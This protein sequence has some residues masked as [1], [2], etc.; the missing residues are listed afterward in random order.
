[1]CAF[2]IIYFAKY[3]VLNW[4]SIE[5]DGRDG[6]YSVHSDN[7]TS[8][9]EDHEAY[10]RIQDIGLCQSHGCREEGRGILV[11]SN[12]LTKPIDIQPPVWLLAATI[13]WTIL[14]LDK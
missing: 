8:Q 7:A 5:A 2:L 6:S 11:R 3:D 1:M 14:L 13:W 9:V 4:L 10:F 12:W